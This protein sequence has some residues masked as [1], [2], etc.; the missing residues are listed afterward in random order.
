VWKE[1]R[2]AVQSDLQAAEQAR[3]NLQKKLDR[4]DEAFLFERS[5]DIDT[6]DRHADRVREQMT[7]LKIDEHTSKLE[8]LEVEGILAFA[9]RVL[10]RAADLWVQAS[11]DQ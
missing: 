1:R 9:E 8:E 4:L 2:S 3:Q 5:I 6:Y 10:P 11:L 7:L